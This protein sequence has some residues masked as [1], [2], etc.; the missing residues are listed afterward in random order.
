MTTGIL[1]L[2]GGRLRRSLLAASEWVQAGRTELD[3]INV[4]PVPDG[5]T[6][7]N[8]SLT[9]RAVA[10]GVA[11]L[12]QRASLAETAQA[13]AR[14][15]VLGARGNSGMLL[16]H[17]LLGFADALGNA[18]RAGARQV[19]AAIREGADRLAAALDDPVEGT[20][21]TVCRETGA[22]AVCHARTA[23]DLAQ[24]LRRSLDCAWHVLGQTPDLLPALREAGVV[25]AGA[26]AF[27]RALEGIV[28]LIDGAPI[29]IATPRATP[30]D[31]PW[32]AGR[33]RV[34]PARDFR[35][36]T[37]VLV[38]GTALPSSL[39][40]RA[41]LKPW[42][43]SVVVISTGDILKL[44]I[45]TD[46]P[47]RIVDLAAAWG[48]VESSKADDVREQHRRLPRSRAAVALVADTSHD[49][50]PARAAEIGLIE[51]PLQIVFGDQVLL[52]RVDVDAGGLYARLR[53]GEAAT[54]SQPTP[55]A[56]REAF[57][58]AAE[59]GEIV[60][61]ILLAR[62]LSGTH[63]SAEAA[64]RGVGEPGPLLVDSRSASLGLGLLVLRAAE[65]VRAG[66][67]ATAIA[68]ELSRVRGQS[69]MYF[70]VDRLDGLV[71]SGRVSGL[72]GWLAGL[73]DLKPIL[74]LTPEGRVVA[75][76][77][78]RGREALRARVLEALERDLTP[79]PRLLRLG[80]AHAD[81]PDVAE[82]LAAEL[83][84]RFAPREIVVAQ[85]TG[86]I[87]AHA[88]PDAWGIFYQVEDGARNSATRARL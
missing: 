9:L 11:A 22:F 54:T 45:H 1:Y 19:A 53:A 56:F 14:A 71:R 13:A 64:A 10:D 57:A 43:G 26:K 3:R 20:I 51:V 8:V 25:D 80:V 16:S 67:A 66:W 75:S 42:G 46:E 47:Q 35:Y 72:R 83:E 49:L 50:P 58:V 6:G 81:C 30:A 17:F 85:A 21:L 32:T 31:A 68:A 65:L 36:C 37:E 52:D 18:Q 59:R 73:L 15:S 87:G 4:F 86:V 38:R 74:S 23:H 55:A 76:G 7:T 60:L 88:G 27:V 2:D 34:E 70:T 12:R 41:V 84:A 33:V 61:A 5:D 69:G 39:E 63:A 48:T 28:R 40:V 79:R 78:A 62:A 29:A 82:G 44:H 77:K 24:L